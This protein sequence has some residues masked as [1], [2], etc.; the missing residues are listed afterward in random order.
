M[1]PAPAVAGPASP[2]SDSSHS[3]LRLLDGGPD[4][5]SRGRHLAAIAL[6]L[7]PGFK[8]YWRHPGD[9]GVP[10]HFQFE[11]SSNL[12]EAH[13]HFP[14]PRRFDDG[15]GGVS[16][17][18]LEPELLLPVTVAAADAAKPVLLRL[19]ADYAVCEKLCVPASGVAE[20]QLGG[21]PTAHGEAIRQAMKTVPR[22]VAAGAPGPVRI[23]GLKR[24][25]KPGTFA[26]AIEAPQGTVP[27]LF[28]E[29]PQP[30]FFEVGAVTAGSP[31]IVP[32]KVVERPSP[33]GGV[34]LTLTLVTGSGAIEVRLPLDGALI[35]S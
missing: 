1:R 8:T 12:R 7:K 4:P 19:K 34:A 24:G 18:Y 35:P 11:G 30:W 6:R 27:E 5:A 20:V 3:A 15:A 28:V 14:A 13:V 32:V 25:T 33:H 21:M 22:V 2:W 16:F 10:P 17:G 31:A 29:A 9:S 23:L 26:V